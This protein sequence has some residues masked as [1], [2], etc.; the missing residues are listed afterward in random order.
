MLTPGLPAEAAPGEFS[1]QSSWR[2]SRIWIGREFWANPLQDWRV[3]DGEVIARAAPGRT[4]HL[5]TH[6]VVESGG[7]FKMEVTVRR[8][9][10]GNDE[11]VASTWAGF[12]FGVRG[13]SCGL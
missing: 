4:L 11:T 5:L 1:F 3:D 2:G 7:G 12:I 8:A 10:S 9:A 13:R 6:Q